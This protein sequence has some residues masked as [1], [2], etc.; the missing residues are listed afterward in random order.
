[1][2]VLNRSIACPTFCMAMTPQVREAIFPHAWRTSLNLSEAYW[3]IPIAKSFQKFLTFPLVGG[4]YAFAVM[5]FW[6]NITPRIFT[7]TCAVIVSYLRER[8]IQIYAYLNDWL[9]VAQSSP[10]C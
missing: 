9:I 7:K 1:M 6:L 3:H 8:G 5:P 2:P 4:A 10:A